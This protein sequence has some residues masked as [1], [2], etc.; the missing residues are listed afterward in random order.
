MINSV[1]GI[2]DSIG[3]LAVRI[4]RGRS[5]VIG[6]AVRGRPRGC[7]G[8]AQEAWFPGTR[9]RAG[10]G[11]SRRSRGDAGAGG[12][13][14]HRLSTRLHAGE[15]ARADGSV[16]TG[17][18]CAGSIGGIHAGGVRLSFL[19]W[20]QFPRDLCPARCG[21]LPLVG[22]P[23]RIGGWA[24]LPGKPGG[25]GAGRRFVR[26]RLRL[27]L[28]GYCPRGPCRIRCSSWLASIGPP[29]IL[30]AGSAHVLDLPMQ[31]PPR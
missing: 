8:G 11:S 23:L 14:V 31:P 17:S 13:S 4:T 18:V 22:R 6:P 16:I 15:S 9:N 26:K 25:V 28:C 24:G 19:E 3:Q 7:V 21:T 5:E 30:R 10:A 20:R 2:V 29:S 1:R 12:D 27:A